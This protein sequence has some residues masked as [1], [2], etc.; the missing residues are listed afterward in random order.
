MT[1][2]PPFLAD[3][4][5]RHKADTSRLAQ[6][7]VDNAK[8]LGYEPEMSVAGSVPTGSKRLKGKARKLAR[9][10]AAKSGTSIPLPVGKRLVKLF[11]PSILTIARRAIRARKRCAEWFRRSPVDDD[12]MK[13]R[14]DKGHWHFVTVLE[15]VVKILTPFAVP[16]VRKET[17]KGD[18]ST[19]EVSLENQFSLLEVDEMEE[20]IEDATQVPPLPPSDGII[21]EEVYDVEYEESEV[22]FATFCLFEDLADIRRFLQQTWTDYREGRID[23]ITASVTTNTAV[24]LVRDAEEELVGLYPY[25]TDYEKVIDVPYVYACVCRGEDP[26]A[27]ERQEDVVNLRMMDVA[28]LLY[29]PTYS[30]LKSLRDVI[31]PKYLPVYNGQFGYYNPR[32]NRESLTQSERMWED[33]RILMECMPDLVLLALLKDDA[34]V[35]DGFTKE[36]GL[37]AF[38]RRIPLVLVFAAQVFIDIHHIFRDKIGCGLVEMRTAGML[39]ASSLRERAET[40]P[41]IQ[42][43]NWPERNET[44]VTWFSKM[45][46]VWFVNDRVDIARRTFH[47]NSTLPS[48]PVEPFFTP[49]TA[50]MALRYDALQGAIDGS[51]GWVVIGRRLG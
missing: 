6:W 30:A 43:P 40:N 44:N 12:A 25:L 18:E 20:N 39:V 41:K 16:E 35:R 33:R 47:R 31:N 27:I 14:K 8:R 15:D 13:A 28:E 48:N 42:L 23:L 10:A 36:F 19:S 26:T 22:I 50:S 1:K 3:S 46:E 51:R 11:R 21:G 37:M 49:E 9:E 7:L 32:Q 2:L 4:H 17:E 5:K 29:I 45:I 24:D 34:L 38:S